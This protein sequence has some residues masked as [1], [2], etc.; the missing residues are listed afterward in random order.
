MYAYINKI[1]KAILC[2]YNMR[3]FLLYGCSALSPLLICSEREESGHG[4]SV[5]LISVWLVSAS[6]P[7]ALNLKSS[8]LEIDFCTVRSSIGV[9]PSSMLTTAD[10]FGLRVGDMLVQRRANFNI[11]KASSLEKSEPRAGSTS[12]S[13]FP[14]S[15]QT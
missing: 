9:F 8:Q 4:Q 6:F 11:C 7:K 14:F 1:I 5:E 12:S 3:K 13:S 10:I 15:W 2:P